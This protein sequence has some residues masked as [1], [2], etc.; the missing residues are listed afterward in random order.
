MATWTI[1][2]VDGNAA[3][4]IKSL[5]LSF[6]LGLSLSP[7]VLNLQKLQV[8]FYSSHVGSYKAHLEVSISLVYCLSSDEVC[9]VGWVMLYKICFA[10]FTPL[11][12]KLKAKFNMEGTSQIALS[13]TYVL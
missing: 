13:L 1:L 11:K 8:L 5:S 9:E 12:G 6:P 3:K 4:C 2:S 7:S 10:E